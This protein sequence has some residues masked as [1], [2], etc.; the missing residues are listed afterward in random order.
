MAK[1]ECKLNLEYHEKETAE[2]IARS[3]RPDNMGYVDCILDES[4]L[5]C[6]LE[7]ENPLQLLHT[8]DDLLMCVTV[9]EKTLKR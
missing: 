2:M 8:V 7:G 3:I 6:H 4:V 5:T 9:T 1:I